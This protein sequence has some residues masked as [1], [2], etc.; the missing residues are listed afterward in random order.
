M[1]SLDDRLSGV[2]LTPEVLMV[3]FR[4]VNEALSNVRRHA[5]A[6][7][8]V[9]AMEPA[10]DGVRV[11]I[12]DDGRGFEPSITEE[13][14]PGH[15]GLRSMQERARLAGGACQVRSAPGFGTTVELW[16]PSAGST[17]V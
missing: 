9:V 10:D 4:I 8:V 17:G 1:P 13:H 12:E 14:D 7:H 2:V 5:A 16:V 6:R 11:T 3:I 15:W